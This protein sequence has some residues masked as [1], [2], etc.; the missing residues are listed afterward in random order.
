M[1][2]DDSCGVC[3]KH[4]QACNHHR[5]EHIMNEKAGHIF[6]SYSKKNPVVVDMAVFKEATIDPG[7]LCLR[8]VRAYEKQNNV[9]VFDEYENF[10]PEWEGW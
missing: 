1:G 7:D 8:C 9:K 6:C 4:Y 10:T 2:Q 5:K 3:G